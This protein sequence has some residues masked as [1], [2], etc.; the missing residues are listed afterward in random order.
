MHMSEKQPQ[1][2]ILKG[3]VVSDKMD[4]TIVVKVERVKTHAKY[5]KK[6]ISSQKYNVHDENNKHKVGDIVSFIEIRPLSKSKRW[7]VVV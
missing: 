6:Y 1:K 5:G 3:I 7:K 4:K 2:R